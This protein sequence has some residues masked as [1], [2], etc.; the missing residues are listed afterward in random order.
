M[1]PFIQAQ[2]KGETPPHSFS[3]QSSQVNSSCNK[4]RPTKTSSS[5]HYTTL[6]LAISPPCKNCCKA[7]S[8]AGRPV[9]SPSLS[10]CYSANNQLMQLTLL[11]QS[12][13]AGQ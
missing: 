7:E 10:T 9:A 8:S 12:V 1:S 6:F 2:G 4:T 13:S 3:S 11:C 5:T